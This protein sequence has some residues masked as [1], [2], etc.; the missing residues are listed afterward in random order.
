MTI[1]INV[2]NLLGVSSFAQGLVIGLAV[3]GMVLFD[4]LSKSRQAKDNG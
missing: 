2:M 1:I 3:I 4:S